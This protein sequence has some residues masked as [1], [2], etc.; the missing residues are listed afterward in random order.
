MTASDRS[1]PLL[2]QLGVSH[3]SEKVRWALD[4][5]RLPHRRRTAMPGIHIPIALWLSGGAVATFPILE[6]GEDRLTD[7]TAAIA[8][9]ERRHP[10]QPLYPADPAERRRA[11]ELEEYFD[12]NLGPAARLLPFHELGSDPELFGEVASHAV[13]P[14]LDR[15]KPLLALYGRLYAGARFGAGDAAAADRARGAI[16]DALERIE[17]A[18]EAGDGVHLAGGEFSVADLT[19]AALFYPVVLPPGGPLPADLR[20]PAELELFR[21]E[22]RDRP[23]YRWVE[24]T[25]RRYR[26]AD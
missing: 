2:W 24:E 8:A 3:Y 22:I 20:Q 11:I 5:K 23:G 16:I 17:A 7:S 19:G 26:G 6:L 25:Y 12:E 10:E 14:P 18:L 15:A 4:Y 1:R 9:L 21:G 13:P